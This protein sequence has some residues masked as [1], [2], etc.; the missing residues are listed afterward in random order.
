MATERTELSTP[1]G[2]L[3]LDQAAVAGAG[4]S[5][6]LVCRLLGE[7]ITAEPTHAG[8]SGSKV[9]LRAELF[10]AGGGHLLFEVQRIESEQP[11]DEASLTT[12][13]AGAQLVKGGLPAIGPS[14]VV[15]P[16]ELAKL[17]TRAA[18]R[19]EKP[20]PS[21]PKAGLLVQN[22]SESLRYVLLDGVVV[23]R[24]LPRSELHIEGLLPGKYGLVT[25]DFAGDDPTPLRI[26]VLPARVALGD[27]VEPLR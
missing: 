18:P 5:G 11:L 10:S 14:L 24:V 7:L 20:E 16:S 1:L 17:R 21:A 25:L 12:T 6:V 19:E 8:C 13:P 9:P 2:R 26:V 27:D 15:P 3:L 23:A 4:S 22:K